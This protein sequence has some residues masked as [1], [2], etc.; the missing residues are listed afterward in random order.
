MHRWPSAITI[1]LWLY[2]LHHINDVYNATPA[3]KSG[4]IPLERFSATTVRPKVFDFHPP[5]CPVYI[6]HNG[7]QGSGS[8]PNKWVKQSSCAVYL[9]KSPLHARSVA[10]V[11]SLLTGYVSAQFHLK[12]DDFFETVKNLNVLPESKWQELACFTQE[13]MQGRAMK[14]LQ[15]AKSKFQ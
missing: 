12:H 5:A 7:L 3:L 13:E 1:S 14:K 4:Q 6:L 10:L 11:L 9:G 15:G 2:A 8:C